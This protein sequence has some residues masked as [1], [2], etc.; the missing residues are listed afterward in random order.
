MSLLSS[1]LRVWPIP[2]HNLP[3]PVNVGG[4]IRD[5]KKYF[6]PSQTLFWRKYIFFK[7]Q[8]TIQKTICFILLLKKCF[9]L[10][11]RRVRFVS[12]QCT[13]CTPCTHH[14][15]GQDGH[16]RGHFLGKHDSCG[17]WLLSSTMNYLSMAWRRIQTEEMAK[18]VACVCGEEILHLSYMSQF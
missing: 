6:N 17:T 14:C 2:S 10:Y 18:F 8:T 7:Y 5:L 12:V 16:G 9:I 3:E 4:K 13:A 1:S 15:T 11:S